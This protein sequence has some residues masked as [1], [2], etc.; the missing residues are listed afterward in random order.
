MFAG[1]VRWTA[2]QPFYA[3][4]ATHVE[5]GV[6]ALRFCSLGLVLSHE[7]AEDYHIEVD[8]A[9]HVDID[10]LGELIH[11]HLVQ[12]W[13]RDYDPR[14]TYESIDTVVGQRDFVQPSFYGGHICDID[15]LELSCIH[16][17]GLGHS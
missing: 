15:F 13:T 10:D 17:V 2:G 16:L 4:L 9:I 3:A 11:L 5:N 6:A 7:V 1:G 8:G 14:A 12:L